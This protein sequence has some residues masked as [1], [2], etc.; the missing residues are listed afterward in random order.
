MQQPGNEGSPPDNEIGNRSSCSQESMR[1]TMDPQNVVL[2]ALS[3]SVP[4]KK[5]GDQ[6][7]LGNNVE[8]VITKAKK[9]ASYLYTLLHAKVSVQRPK[10]LKAP[11]RKTK[12]H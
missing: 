2:S 11:M 7:P 3:P 9:A 4:Q 8:S 12:S 1:V 5:L 6:P 10:L